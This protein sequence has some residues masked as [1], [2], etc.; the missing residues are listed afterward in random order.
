MIRFRSSIIFLVPLF[1]IVLGVSRADAQYVDEYLQQIKNG[2]YEKARAALP[3]LL[4]EHPND[5]G[6]LYLRGVLE[7]EGEQAYQYFKDLADN[8]RNHP[9]MDDAIMQV[10]EYL[11]AKGLYISA[12]RYLRQI[13]IH[14]PRS[15][16]LERASN[17][18]LNS[19]VQAGKVDSARTWKRVLSRQFPNVTIT[20]S[21]EAGTE[22][23]NEDSMAALAPPEPVDLSKENPYVD[24]ESEESGTQSGSA[25]SSQGNR[26]PFALQVGA[27]STMENARQQQQM[28]ENYG[29]PVQIR[30]RERGNL[31]LYLV[32]VG[33]YSTRAEASQA[34]E[35]LKQRMNL[36]F[37]I[38]K[39]GN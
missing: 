27:Y 37:F 1:A 9:Y 21:L 31:Q 38:V 25:G 15:P 39:K 11:Y 16:Y 17:M 33:N 5:P 13:P 23:V 24:T 3:Q 29:Y 14:H 35:S 4:Q 12:E 7:S 22:P 36:P 28:L 26:Q 2:H 34:G 8:H 6:V 32:W 10:A 19:M 20:S 18:L 30:Q